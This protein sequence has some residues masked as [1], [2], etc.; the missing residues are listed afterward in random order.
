MATEEIIQR[1]APE[2]EAYKLGLMEQAKA[3]TS[4]PPTGGLPAIQSAGADPLQTRASNL[5][6]AG[7]GTYQ[8]QLAAAQQAFT[9]GIGGLAGSQ[10]QYG[11][12]G[13]F[14]AGQ[15]DPRSAQAFMNPYQQAVQ[16]E[17]MR[18]YDI[19][20]NQAA[21][22]ASQAGAFG[23]SRQAVQQS[24]L[25]RNEASALA[26]SQADN[27]LQAQQ[28]AMRDFERGEGSRQAAFESR[29]GRLQSAYEAARNRA[30]QGAQQLGQ[31][32]VQQ[33]ALGELGSN[34]NRADVQSLQN[35]GIMNR[36]IAQ[37]Q[38]EAQRQTD[39]QTAYEPYQRLG[40]YS[41]ILRGAPTTQSTITASSAANP[42]LLNQIVGGAASGLGLYGAAN[43]TGLI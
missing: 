23:G 14:V 24:E 13:Q 3:L 5:A 11:G 28:A 27:Y 38:L 12:V 20:R 36:D 30:L 37:Q 1:E 6:Q 19:Q 35:M 21:S 32:G 9:S 43:K 34:L 26:R 7:I 41:D 18:S 15:Y 31:F 42:S 40:F 33:A 4:A 29:E 2:I 16:D 8:P 22:Q 17:I 25:G 39:M 10:G